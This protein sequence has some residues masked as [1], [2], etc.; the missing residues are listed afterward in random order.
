MPIV[1]AIGDGLAGDRLTR[2]VGILNGTSNVVLSRM[3]AT[4]C[5]LSQAAVAEARAAG[6]A[7][8]DPS[9]DLDGHDARAKLAILCAL[10]FG[11]RVDPARIETRSIA[12]LQLADIEQARRRGGTIR[13]LAFAAVRPAPV[14]ADR[15]GGAGHRRRDSLFAR[16]DR[17]GQRRHRERPARGR[18]S[19][20]SAPGAGG[21]ATAVAVVADLLAIARDRAGHRPAP[22][23]T[24]PAVVTGLERG[25]HIVDF[26]DAGR[27]LRGGGMSALV[28]LQCHL[29]QT[30]FPAEALYV[31]DQCLGPLEPVYD[32]DAMHLTREAIDARPKNLWRY[33]ELLPIAGEPRTG[34]HSGFTPL[35]RCDRLAERLG[36]ERALHQGRFGATIRRC[37][38]RTASS[39]SRRRARSSSGSTC[40][41]ARPPATSP[42][43]S[44]RTRRGSASN[45]ASSSRTTSKRARSSA[46]RST[47]RPFSRSPATTTM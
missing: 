27:S 29:C 19:A 2:I 46:P 13:Q 9:A 1:R 23:L 30:T 4:G 47:G 22:L 6:Y 17:P 38:T 21:E 43:A 36:V 41:P 26:I 31:C 45:A 10:G 33:R 14:D 20:S 8:A 16:D 44:R 35:V 34:F 3:E 15:L 24:M 42:T 39:R 7:E 37:P 32:Y 18:R 28:G 40:S 25:T 5:S 11:L 12:S